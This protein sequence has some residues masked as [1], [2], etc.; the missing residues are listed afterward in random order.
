MTGP[1][2]VFDVS[3]KNRGIELRK[4]VQFIHFLQCTPNRRGK[5]IQRE[6]SNYDSIT[7]NLP[8]AQVLLS[9]APRDHMYSLLEAPASILICN[10][11]C[12]TISWYRYLPVLPMVM[13]DYVQYRTVLARIKSLPRVRATSKRE[14]YTGTPDAFMSLG[15]GSGE[16]GETFSHLRCAN[17]DIFIRGSASKPCPNSGVLV[18]SK[19]SGYQGFLVLGADQSCNM[20]VLPCQGK[21]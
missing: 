10:A 11:G 2:P 15:L 18:C 8:L 1:L 14:C 19:V 17:R 6:A 5:W 16:N 13:V 21:C 12:G 7:R 3:N 20:I 9:T 4:H